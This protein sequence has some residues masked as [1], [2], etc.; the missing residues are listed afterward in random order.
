ME[1]WQI[2][3]IISR[4]GLTSAAFA[5]AVGLSTAIVSQMATGK[6]P[7]TAQSQERIKEAFPHVNAEWMDKG[8]GPY[9]AEMC[10][11][12]MPSLKS[13]GGSADGGDLFYGYGRNLPD[14]SGSSTKSGGHAA[15]VGSHPENVETSPSAAP[16]RRIVEIKVFYDD[17]TYETYRR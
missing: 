4:E 6:R 11:N 15:N 2:K 16:A 12:E 5:E 7:I 1:S 10:A 8:S 14:K 13:G 3:E 9:E 17:G